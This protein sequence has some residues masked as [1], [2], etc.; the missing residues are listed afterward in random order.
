M[1]VNII[2]ARNPVRIN[3][4]RRFPLYLAIQAKKA[5]SISRYGSTTLVCSLVSAIKQLHPNYNVKYFF[6]VFIGPGLYV[7]TQVPLITLKLR[8]D[9]CLQ[10]D[11]N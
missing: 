3:V 10:P 7:I 6:G 2:W 4:V 8:L 5:T 11:F 1:K 9:F